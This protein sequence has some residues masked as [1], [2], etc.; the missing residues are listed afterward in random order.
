MGTDYNKLLD[1]LVQKIKEAA[2]REEISPEEFVR[3]A[4]EARLSRAEWAKTLE[5]GSQNAREK[6]IRPEDVDTEL[7]ADRSERG[8]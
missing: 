6:G 3:D 1:P 4:V 2:A 7:A 8:R 5:F